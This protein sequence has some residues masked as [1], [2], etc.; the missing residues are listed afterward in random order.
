MNTKITFIDPPSPKTYKKTHT[1][2]NKQ[3]HTHTHTHTHKS[4][5]RFIRKNLYKILNK[6]F[7]FL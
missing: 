2:T 4:D 3:T 6:S 7:S 1:Q 5:P